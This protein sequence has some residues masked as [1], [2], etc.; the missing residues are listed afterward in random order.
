MKFNIFCPNATIN[1]QS[2]NNTQMTNSYYNLSHWCLHKEQKYEKRKNIT[3]VLIRN[4]L[5][6]L[7]LECF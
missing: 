6:T 7:C 3:G 2:L 1:S 5:N 4:G